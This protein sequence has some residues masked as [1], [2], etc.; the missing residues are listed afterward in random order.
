MKYLLV[1]GDG[2]A[3]EPL[4][5]LGGKTPIEYAKTPA[6]DA[7]ASAGVLGDVLT[8]PQGMQAGSDTA[9]LSIFGYDPK[10]YLSGRAALEAAA[11]NISLAPG[12]IAYRCNIV[13]FEDGDLP[14]HDKKILSHS[15]KIIPT[16]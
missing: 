5:E 7:L 1:I 14:F 15:A 12:D 8:V 11:Q 6:M 10:I 13:T 9:I 3:D 16:E 2:M 4:P